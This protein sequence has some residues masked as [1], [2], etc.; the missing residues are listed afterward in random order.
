MGLWEM[1]YIRTATGR[2]RGALRVST[3]G[4]IRV[5]SEMATSPMGRLYSSSSET[6]SSSRCLTWTRKRTDSA[7]STMRWS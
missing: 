6:G 5:F 4:A 7:P 3:E 1:E 2:T